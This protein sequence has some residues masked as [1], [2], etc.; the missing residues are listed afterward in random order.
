MKPTTYTA[1]EA[2][3]DDCLRRP[4]YPS[5]GIR[6]AWAALPEWAQ[7]S[8]RRNPTPRNWPAVTKA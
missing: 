6:P 1:E 3:A 2:Y 7:W 8:W 5:G 4:T